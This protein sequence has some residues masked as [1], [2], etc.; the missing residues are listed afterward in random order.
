V[1]THIL[2]TEPFRGDLD[3]DRTL[4]YG[5][6]RR[7]SCFVAY[8]G[9]GDATGFRFTAQSGG[10]TVTM[11]REIALDGE[12]SLEVTSP[13]QAELRLLRNGRVVSSKRGR[14]LRCATAESG[15]YRVE[16]YRPYLFKRRGWVFTNPIYVRP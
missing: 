6:L 14:Q 3:H 2:A 8:D 1:R 5:A 13:L 4:V 12:V 11:G 7:G 9:I 16:A 10:S 15:V